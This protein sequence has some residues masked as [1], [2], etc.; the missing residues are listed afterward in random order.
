MGTSCLVIEKTPILSQDGKPTKC[1]AFRSL[2]HRHH[3]RQCRASGF[4]LGTEAGLYQR[5][6][7]EAVICGPGD[8]GRAHKPDE[9]ILMDELAACQ[10]LVEALGR[11]C[12]A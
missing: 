3:G 6:G 2:L 7:L 12:L 11:R 8:I 4:V 5:A 1:T 9:F 10:A